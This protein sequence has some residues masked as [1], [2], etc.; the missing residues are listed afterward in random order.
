[1]A[2]GT[3]PTSASLGAITLNGPVLSRRGSPAV[4]GQI[5]GNGV[6]MRALFRR[7][8]DNLAA[9]LTYTV[10]FSADLVT[11]QDSTDVPTAVASDSEID[12]V[13][14]PFPA[15]LLSGAKT[16]VFRVRVSAP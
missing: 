3:V 10:Q 13:T 8:K 14:V 2:L 15:A 5:T 11:W 9:G 4:W 16:V 7:R 12:A 1:M 6:E